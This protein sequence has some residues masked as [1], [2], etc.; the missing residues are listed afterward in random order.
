MLQD[1]QAALERGDHEG[2]LRLTDELL[3]QRP[4]ED[5]AHEYRARALLALGRL[6]EAEQHA[7]DAVR[8]DPDEI[9][10]RELLAQVLS[11]AGAHRD[12]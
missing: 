5:A 9:R 7:Q 8:L 12:A 10:Y 3:A 1:V 2:V 11:E 4:G 6:D